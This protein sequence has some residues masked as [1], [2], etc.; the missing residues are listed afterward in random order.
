V[1]SQEKPKARLKKTT[2]SKKNIVKSK[3]YIDKTNFSDS[4]PFGS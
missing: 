4:I 2:K 1:E 3:I